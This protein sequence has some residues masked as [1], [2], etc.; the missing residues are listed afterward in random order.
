MS[1]YIFDKDGTLVSFIRWWVFPIAPIHPREQ[2]LLPGIF[3]RLAALRAAGHRLA[4][5]SNQRDVALGITTFEQAQTLMK[6]CAAK[7]GGVDAWRF[8]PYHPKAPEQLHGQPNPYCRDDDRRK[9]R[10]GMLLE[11]MQELGYPASD[12]F[13]VGDSHHDRLAAEAA[14]ISFIRSKQFFQGE[15]ETSPGV[16]QMTLKLRSYSPKI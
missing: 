16:S 6:N 12:T 7:V 4:I 5:A 15:K 9:P 8:C 10:P 1:L 13:M 14:G 3:E 2:I 11:I